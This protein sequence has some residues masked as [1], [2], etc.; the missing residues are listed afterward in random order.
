M[1]CLRAVF[2]L[3]GLFEAQSDAEAASLC[4]DYSLSVSKRLESSDIEPTQE[5]DENLSIGIS[6][7]SVVDI[8]MPFGFMVVSYG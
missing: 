1:S 3:K 5:I 2:N 4:T 6:K 7:V 8:S